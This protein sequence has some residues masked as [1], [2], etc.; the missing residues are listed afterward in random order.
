M[1]RPNR[2]S[3]DATLQT[4]GGS[5]LAPDDPFFAHHTAEV[6]GVRIH[7]VTAGRGDPVLLLHGWPQTWYEWRHLIP[8]L[9]EHY[10]VVAP[11]LRGMG[12]SDK[13]PAGY[14]ERTVAEDIHGLLS[15]LNLG[16]AFVVGHDIG[17]MAAYA[18]AA[19]HPDAVRRLA[20][21]E[22]LL[23]GIDPWDRVRELLWHF[24]FHAV[25]DLPEA[26][27]AGHERVY[28]SWSY[29]T[30]AYDPAAIGEEEIDEYVRAYAS[31]AAPQAAFNHYRAFPQ[32]VGHNQE[33]AATLLPMPVLALGGEQSMGPMVG[34]TFQAVAGDVRAEV[35]PEC[36]HWMPEEQHEY[37]AERLLA[38][39]DEEG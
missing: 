22:G 32:D 14:D 11:D 26:L 27:V 33:S 34:E 1:E 7:Y 3:P 29:R 30:F 24:D 20:V 36:G 4:G 13:P 37:L 23:P 35:V 38:F 16:P 8:V 5:A 2:L 6:D 39:F 28:L 21:V 15:Q 12:D 31:E 17:L 10:T 19:A 25:P 9:A 18:Y